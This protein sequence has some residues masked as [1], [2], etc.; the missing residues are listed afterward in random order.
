MKVTVPIKAWSTSNLREHWGARARRSQSQRKA[1]ALVSKSLVHQVA[2][3]L[4]VTLTRVAPRA[5]DDDNLRGAL[6]AVRD[7]VASVLRVDDRSP[8]VRWEYAQRRGEPH[9][10]AVEIDFSSA[11]AVEL[12]VTELGTEATEKSPA[13]LRKNSR[14]TPKEQVVQEQDSPVKQVLQIETLPTAAAAEDRIGNLLREK[15]EAEPL[16]QRLRRLARPA[17]VNHREGSDG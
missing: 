12:E 8:L 1:T 9:E 7:A 16:A 13:G 15:R 5:L 14:S 11:K 3:V 6:K 4:V 2:T 17:H 10:Y